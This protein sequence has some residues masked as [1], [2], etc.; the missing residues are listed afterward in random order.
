MPKGTPG[1][2]WLSALTSLSQINSETT[3]R[4]SSTSRVVSNSI[5][6]ATW[7]LIVLPM[8]SYVRCR[9]NLWPMCCN[10]GAPLTASSRSRTNSVLIKGT[11]TVLSITRTTLTVQAKTLKTKGTTYPNWTPS[12]LVRR[13]AKTSTV[14][15]I[16]S[17]MI[18]SSSR[19]GC[20]SRNSIRPTRSS[21][22][23]ES[24]LRSPWMESR[25]LPKCKEKRLRA[26]RHWTSCWNSAEAR[27]TMTLHV[28]QRSI[29]GW[30]QMQMIRK[31]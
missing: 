27:N 1:A 16:W 23:E 9:S 4:L 3:R 21:C 26:S 12:P 18:I 31:N 14:Q 8:R 30:F 22:L 28:T 10:K 29:L 25:D 13:K 24:L 5:P 2:Q 15:T 17:I 20:L 19:V 7:T 6:R 11:L